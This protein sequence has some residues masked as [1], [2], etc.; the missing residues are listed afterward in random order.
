MSIVLNGTTGISASGNITAGGNLSVGG[1]FSP[2]SVSTTGNVTG[3]NVLTAGA[4]SATGNVSGNYFIGNGSLLTG[5]TG[6]GGG[7]NGT[8]IVNGNSNVNIATSGANVT[9]AVGGSSDVMVVSASQ[10]QFAGN[11]IPAANVTYNLGTSSSRWNDIWLANSTI[12]IGDANISAD[13]ANLSLPSNVAIG[14]VTLTTASGNLAL[15]AG[16]T[17]GSVLAETPRCANVQ[18]ATSTWTV[19]DDTAVALEGGYIIINGAGFVAGASVLVGSVAAASVTVVNSTTIRAQVNAA[20]AGTYVIYVTNPDGSVGILVPGLTYSGT[21][22]WVTGSTLPAQGSNVAISIQ[23]EATGATSYSLSAG[24]TLPTG[25]SLSAGG[26]LSGTV[27]VESETVYS[28]SVDAID[29]EL[30]ESP[31]TFSVTLTAGDGYFNYVTMLLPG[32]GTNGAQNNTFL[33][34]ST[35][36][37][38]I[39]R[40]GN[41]TQGSFSPF[42]HVDGEWSNYFDGS[43]DYLSYPSNTAFQFGTGDFTIEFWWNPATLASTQTILYNTDNTSV[44]GTGQYGIVYNTSLGLRLYINGGATAISQGATTGWSVGTWYHVAVV[45]NGNTV[46]IY[47]N[48]TSIASGS[49]TGVTIGA[50]TTSY[51]GGEPLD[52]LY[53]TGY[54]SNLRIVKGTAVYTAAFTPSVSPLTAISGTSLLTCQSN[55]FR[56][57]SAN[58]FA[59]TAVGNPSIQVFSPFNPTA[60]YSTSTNGGSGY[61]DGNGDYLTVPD[62]AAFDF[63]TGDFTMETWVYITDLPDATGQAIFGEINGYEWYLYSRSSGNLEV[64]MQ[65]FAAGYNQVYTTDNFIKIN[66]WAHV[67]VARQSGTLRVFV[68]GVQCT[69]T[70]SMPASLN[71]SAT[72]NIGRSTYNSANF[73]RGY[74]SDLRIVKGT[75][76]YTAAFTPPTAPLTAISGTSFLMSGTNAAIFDAAAMNDLD[77]VGNAQIST[78]QSKFGGGSMLFDGTGD[79]L[80]VPATQ[81][82]AFGTGDF[83]IEFWMYSADVGT[84]QRGMLQTSTTAGGFSTAYDT[85]IIMYQGATLSGGTPVN[86]SGGLIANIIG[87]YVGSTTA[88]LSTNTWYHIALTRSS[89]AVRLFVNGTQVGST[90]TVTGAVNGTNMVIGG[91]YNSSYLYNGYIDDFRITKGYARYISNFTPPTTAVPLN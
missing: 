30:Q 62:N 25:L 76:V 67:A 66:R 83:T 42:S 91:Y 74:M 55:R 29:A 2:A 49:V 23:L 65:T 75:A 69:T 56:D 3:G 18:I 79:Y 43:G 24:N 64:G 85:G 63:G 52:P 1:S 17:V 54:F 8:A 26:L 50:A 90:T 88:V 7:G 33:D 57:N 45:R 16:T 4:V 32:D 59:V 5:I 38:T 87:S 6:G 20:A 40:G 48:G 19:K 86:A 84:S 39:T 47:R 53:C 41:A 12:H 77:T 28:F 35:N 44:N 46:T 73:F 70:G 82:V 14:S 61:F 31:R 9:V 89:G 60:A 68:N 34:S 22:T 71:I 10:A 11:V 78:A 15:P 72:I 36:N 37:F 13:G 21:P 51:F 80:L 58:N 81:N 27:A